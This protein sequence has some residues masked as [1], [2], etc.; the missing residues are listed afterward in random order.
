MR[1]VKK[2]INPQNAKYISPTPLARRRGVSR[3]ND[4]ANRVRTV[5]GSR[6]VI[7]D[8]GVKAQVENA[9]INALENT[10]PVVRKKFMMELE[11]LIG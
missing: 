4:L 1:I 2:R 11:I 9:F 3:L 5:T 6:L 8:W 10:N 7:A